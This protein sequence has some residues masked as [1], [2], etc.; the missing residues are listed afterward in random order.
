[1]ASGRGVDLGEP[2]RAI[3]FANMTIGHYGIFSITPIWILLPFGFVLGVDYGPREFSRL[4]VA[5]MIATTV[6]LAVLL[7]ASTNRPQL[8]RC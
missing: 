7:D 5:I 6:C 3:Y 8:W 1:M 2:S 4:V